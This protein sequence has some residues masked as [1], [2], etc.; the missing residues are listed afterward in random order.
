MCV[1]E[2]RVGGFGLS[3]VITDKELAN[4]IFITSYMGSANSSD[5]TRNRAR[6][7]SKEIG[8]YHVD[9]KVDSVVA[10]LVQLFSVVTGAFTSKRRVYLPRR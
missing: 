10:A 4:R 2:Y 3:E 6:T 5:D 7:L 1:C 8:A 9:L